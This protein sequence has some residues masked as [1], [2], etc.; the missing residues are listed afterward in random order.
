M[1]ALPMHEQGTKLDRQFD[2]NAGHRLDLINI[3]HSM[4]IKNKIPIPFIDASF[5]SRAST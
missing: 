3:R 5:F 2:D 4:E 1:P